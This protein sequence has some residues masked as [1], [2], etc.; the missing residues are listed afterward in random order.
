MNNYEYIN[1]VLVNLF[2]D[3][4]Y[5]EEEAMR[6]TE[7][8]DLTMNDWHV[9][10]AIGINEPKSMSSIAKEL[11]ITVGSL[12]TAMNGLYK[13]GYVNRKR[14][15]EDRRLVYISLTE[16]GESAYKYHADFH[17]EMVNAAVA[18]HS[19]EEIRVLV[20]S[21]S[22]LTKFFRSFGNKT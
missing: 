7:Y 10:E 17:R 9:I 18:D 16:K 12:T 14:G 20:D 15:E 3:I 4:L 5:L 21:L 2:R 22:K 11:S 8:K 19:P 13:K 1:D 6:G